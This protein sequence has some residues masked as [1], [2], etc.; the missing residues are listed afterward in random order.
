MYNVKIYLLH[1][2]FGGFRLVQYLRAITFGLGVPRRIAWKTAGGGPMGVE[3]A[4]ARVLAALQ[5]FGG[6]RFFL[7]RSARK[8][9]V[10]DYNLVWRN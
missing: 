1:I 2:K 10:T 3:L 9:E 4:G 7:R 6:F 5:G 8:D